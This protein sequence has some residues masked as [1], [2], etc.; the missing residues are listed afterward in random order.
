MNKQEIKYIKSLHQKKYRKREGKFLVEGEK[1][2]LE[3]LQSD[4]EIDKLFY[5]E[6]FETHQHLFSKLKEHQLVKTKAKDLAAAGTFV[7]NKMALAVVKSKTAQAIPEVQDLVLALDAVRDPGNMGTI[8]RIA[9]WYGIYHIICSPDTAD[10]Q[11]PKVISA[12]K[13]SFTRVK[14]HYTDLKEYLDELPPQ[15]TI[16]GALLKGENIHKADLI[17]PSIVVMGNESTGIS[18]ALIPSIK[19]KLTIPSFGKAESLNV[20]IATA[21][22]CD[23]FRRV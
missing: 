15:I 23:A 19:R 10:W 13:G 16:A 21:I 7:T 2:V 1:D 22:M 5:T 18:D 14:V 20:G 9:D 11:N 6:K 17:L 8:M 4:F 3:V 12:S